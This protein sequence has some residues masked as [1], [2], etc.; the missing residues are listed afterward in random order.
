MEKDKW[1][2]IIRERDLSDNDQYNIGIASNRENAL[3]MIGNYYG[4]DAIQH[5][6]IDVRDSNVDFIIDVIVHGG[7]GGTYR[8]TVEE[9][10]IDDAS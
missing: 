8:V 7:L 6:F 1:V 10:L 5:N 2:L 9:Y 4:K 3:N